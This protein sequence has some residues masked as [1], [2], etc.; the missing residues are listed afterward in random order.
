MDVKQPHHKHI[1]HTTKED[2]VSWL[3][4]TK[5]KTILL[6]NNGQGLTTIH[7]EDTG[8]VLATDAYMDVYVGKFL[9]LEKLLPGERLEFWKNYIGWIPLPNY[10][11]DSLILHSKIKRALKYKPQVFICGPMR[12]IEMLNIEAF[13]L[14]ADQVL[15]HGLT[16]II[17]HELV[18]ELDVTESEFNN[19]C[20]SEI[21]RCQLVI[22]LPNWQEDTKSNVQ[23][24]IARILEKVIVT[25]SVAEKTLID[26]QKKFFED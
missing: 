21:T 7:I 10:I 3:N 2:F 15:A 9:N 5:T 23:V 13:R 17:P 26:F 1:T 11:I 14:V 20:I 12:G 16:P 19:V 4:E 8:E 25:A 6:K 24:K 18:E 22:T